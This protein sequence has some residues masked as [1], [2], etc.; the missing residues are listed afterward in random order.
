MGCCSTGA[1]VRHTAS[2]VFLGDLDGD[3]HVYRVHHINLQLVSDP[4]IILT[5]EEHGSDSG[6]ESLDK[7]DP[8]D[9]LHCHVERRDQSFS[10]AEMTEL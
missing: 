4:V 9:I 3:E 8:R 2:V 10:V 5:K 7:H 1:Q 6:S